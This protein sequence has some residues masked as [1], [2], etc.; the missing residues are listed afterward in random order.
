MAQFTCNQ[1]HN[2]TT[3]M[4]MLH[5]SLFVLANLLM[6]PLYFDAMVAAQSI[7]LGPWEEAHATFYGGSDAAGTMGMH[8]NIHT[9]TQTNIQT[10]KQTNIHT[11]NIVFFFEKR[12]PFISVNIHTT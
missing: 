12:Y 2:M 5:I 6:C 9:Y 1:A 10:N 4:F 11:Y 3:L 7:A 8:T